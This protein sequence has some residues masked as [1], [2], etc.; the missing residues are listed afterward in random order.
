MQ[1]GR[2]DHYVGG[3]RL[4]HHG[5]YLGAVSGSVVTVL[6]V[7]AL[8]LTACQG[9]SS[10]TAAPSTPSGAV[11]TTVAYVLTGERLVAYDATSGARLWQFVPPQPSA[12]PSMALRDGILYVSDGALYAL[13]A[14]DGRTL[15]QTPLGG[16]A[17]VSSVAVEGGMAYVESSGT[18][19]AV[20]VD[21]GQLAWRVSVGVGLNALLVDGDRVYVGAGTSG[22]VTA[23]SAADGTIRWQIGIGADT[24][25]ALQMVS[26]TLYVSTTF[27]RLLALSPVDGSVHWA[28]QDPTAQALSQPVIANGAV[29]VTM[30]SAAASTNG[31]GS[32]GAQT[33]DTVLA[34]RASDGRAIWRRQFPIGQTTA[35][36]GGYF[37]PVLSRDEATIYAVVGPT[38]GNVVALSAATGALRWQVP[39][40]DTLTAL[41][42]AD[43]NVVYTGGMSGM[44]TAVDI[45]GKTR[46]RVVLGE[47]S[48]VL[49]LVAVQGTIYVAT[50]DGTCAAVDPGIGRMRWQVAGAGGTTTGLGPLPPGILVAS[51]A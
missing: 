10:D 2:A 13:R 42:S 15:W 21:D 40:G 20:R 22:G 5:K 31:A 18:V 11:G 32:I 46:W 7:V 16:G 33:D 44:V 14:R 4:N 6:I 17:F 3:Q 38:A 51:V 50:A 36:V 27:K 49:R 34:L 24:A 39:G 35:P 43:A 8:A 23:L 25:Y 45:D 29:Y 12:M 37:G 1:S 28:H 48:P 47:R 26:G 19:Y 30:R 41:L 9:A